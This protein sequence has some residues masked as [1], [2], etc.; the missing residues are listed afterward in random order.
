VRRAVLAA[1]SQPD[2]M[3]AVTNNDPSAYNVCHSFFPCTTPYGRAPSPDPMAGA[4]LE[5]ARQMLRASGYNGEKVTFLNPSDFTS[6]APLGLIANDL[7]ERI[8]FNM[9]FVSTDW[10]TVLGRVNNRNP[11]AQGGWNL[12]PVWWS[13]MGIVTPTQNAILRGQGA[14]GWSGWYESA[15][16]EALNERWL[17]APDEA[18]RMA[19]GE[20]MQDL[21]FRDVPTVPLGQFFIRTAYRR[22]LTGML[23]GPRPV[24]WNIRRA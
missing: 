14:G 20:R 8:G 15:E 24:P 10:G 3:A 9:D 12:Y 11:P 5:K 19:L 7:L 18:A 23:E 22:S 16:M 6:I 1:I 4:G 21:A 2:F 13:G 17:S